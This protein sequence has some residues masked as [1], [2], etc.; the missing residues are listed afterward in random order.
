MFADDLKLYLSFNK[1]DALYAVD[2]GQSN[3][4]Q[5]V[6]AGEAWG[7]KMNASKCV[8]IRFSRRGHQ[9]FLSHLPM[10]KI[11]NQ[12][13]SFVES[14]RD[15]GITVDSCLKFHMHIKN[16]VNFINSL[17][18]NIL[19][20]TLSRDPEFLLSIYTLHIRPLIE[21]GSCLWNTGYIGDLKLLE[22]IQ[23]RWTRSVEGMEEL[24]YWERLRALNLF[25]LQGRFL[26]ADLILV[27]KIFHGLCALKPEN[28]FQAA[29]NV[30][31]RGHRFKIYAPL[32]NLEIRR[33]FFAVR[34]VAHWNAL[35]Q[36]TVEATSLE[37]F[38]S[39]LHRDLADSLFE[40][41]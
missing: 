14:H 13:I 39:L 1:R 16:R 37:S 4:D 26:R 34:V 15:L 2:Q 38:K 12:M 24:P 36:D 20:C 28:L 30:H 21:Y 25:S 11:N 31:T 17:T 27:Y 6:R 8:C 19:S 41:C 29:N 23:R 22:R 40:F 35:G 7:L 18:T 33:R 32:T 10:Y 3:I 9:D 5:L